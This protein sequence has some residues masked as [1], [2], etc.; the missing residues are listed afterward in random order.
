ML[1]SRGTPNKITA[2]TSQKHQNGNKKLKI[3]CY[4]VSNSV[5]IKSISKFGWLTY[6]RRLSNLCESVMTGPSVFLKQLSWPG[7][8]RKGRRKKGSNASRRL[9]PEQFLIILSPKSPPLSMHPCKVSEEDFRKTLTKGMHFFYGPIFV[10]GFRNHNFQYFHVIPAERE[11]RSTC[12]QH[13]STSISHKHWKR[14]HRPTCKTLCSSEAIPAAIP[15]D[16]S[17]FYQKKLII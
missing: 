9:I 2:G 14:L 12:H 6:V 1:V 10:Y 16:V 3:S 8:P 5:S 15:L 17:L 4:T 7:V 13:S 11:W